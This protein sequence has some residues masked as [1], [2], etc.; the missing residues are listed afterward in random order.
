[1]LRA[2]GF[3]RARRTAQFSGD[4]GHSDVVIDDLNEFYI[5]VKRAEKLSIHNVMDKALS[6][7]VT[8][9]IPLIIHRR[10]QREWLL[11]IRCDDIW[12]FYDAMR[13][14][15]SQESLLPTGEPPHSGPLKTSTPLPE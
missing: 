7:C 4:L 14:F 6:Q 9:Q 1:M 3:P 5:E 13:R 12:E 11:T 10:N 15:A 2:L 8:P